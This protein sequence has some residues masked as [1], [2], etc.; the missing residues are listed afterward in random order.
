[1]TLSQFLYNNTPATTSA[2][3][4]AIAVPVGPRNVNKDFPNFPT[5]PPTRVKGL[6]NFFN[7]VP[8]KLNVF[9]VTLEAVVN[10]LLFDAV[11]NITEPNDLNGDITLPAAPPNDFIIAEPAELIGDIAF[12]AP[13]PN[14]ENIFITPSGTFIPEKLGILIVANIAF[15]ALALPPNV[16]KVFPTLPTAF[17]ILPIVDKLFPKIEIIGPTAATANAVFTTISFCLSDNPLNFSANFCTY[18]VRFLTYGA[19]LSPK[20]IA[21]LCTGDFNIVNCPFKLLLATLYISL[22]APLDL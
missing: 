15:A 7:P 19:N 13:P 10:T 6:Y 11:C 9:P 2:P 17:V 5:S 12:F 8:N 21:K 14:F 1:M 4:T 20:D 22:Q 3:I 18:V 16:F